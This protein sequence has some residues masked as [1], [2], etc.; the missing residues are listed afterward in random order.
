LAI[1]YKICTAADWKA[2]ERDGKLPWSEADTDDGFV[3]MSA[4]DQV[5]ETAAKHF[6]GERDLFLLAV[7]TDRLDAQAL[8]WEVSRGGEKFPHLYGDLPRDAVVASSRLPMGADGVVVIADTL[9]SG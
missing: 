9:I 3:H 1:V 2:C 7:D 6:R 5:R 4:A 8:R